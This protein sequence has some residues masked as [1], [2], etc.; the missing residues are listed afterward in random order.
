M[1]R[2]LYV[3]LLL[4]VTLNVAA[5]TVDQCDSEHGA[6]KPEIENCAALEGKK[7]NVTR[8]S[9]VG[10]WVFQNSELGLDFSMHLHADGRYEGTGINAEGSVNSEGTWTLDDR[11]LISNVTL[12]TN[13]NGATSTEKAK[14]TSYIE[15]V[16]ANEVSIKSAHSDSVIRW[17]RDH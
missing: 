16:S 12:V 8:D 11:A 7:E 10:R 15:S 17:Q 3:A 4:A 5:Q 9:L 13:R 6:E 14:N 2:A 1:S